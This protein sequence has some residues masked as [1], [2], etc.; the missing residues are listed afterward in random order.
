M[1][2]NGITPAF[3]ADDASSILA[4]RSIFFK[5]EVVELVYTADLKSAAELRLAGSSPAF[6]TIAGIAQLAEHLVYTEA[7]GGSSP[8]ART[9]LQ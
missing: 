4:T 8:S 9:M 2:Y 5:G 1:S 3:Q 6:A 7:V